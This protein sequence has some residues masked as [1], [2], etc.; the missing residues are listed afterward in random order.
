MSKTMR[1]ATIVLV[2]AAAAAVGGY[3]Y[4]SP[5]LALRSMQAAAQAQDAERFNQYVDY[6][7]L[8]ES[9]KGQFAAHMTEALKSSGQA[10]SDM[11]RAGE[12]LGV[13]LGMAFVDKLID[14]MVRPEVVMRAMNEARLRPAPEG[15][16]AE[17]ATQEDSVRWVVERKGFDRVIAYGG[18]AG[19]AQATP[20]QDIGFVFDRS[21]F[22]HWRLTEIRLPPDK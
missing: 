1:N 6:A 3:W 4:W 10:G 2:L 15:P 19:R 20:G 22:A 18:D 13:M 16:S 5:L 7:K 8:R 12:A 17:P 11:E 21:G 9:L 14:T